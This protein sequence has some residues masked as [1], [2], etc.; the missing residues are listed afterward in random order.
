[1]VV[2]DGIFSVW[3]WVFGPDES[4]YERLLGVLYSQGRPSDIQDVFWQDW[5]RQG[6]DR[7]YEQDPEEVYGEAIPDAVY[8]F[9]NQ[10]APTLC[11]DRFK[12][13]YIKN[14]RTRFSFTKEKVH[15]VFSGTTTAPPGKQVKEVD[16]EI[17]ATL[18]IGTCTIVLKKGGEEYTLP[19]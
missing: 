14:E 12:I 18:D 17:E 3:R 1:M 11:K 19:A 5:K 10:S 4:P 9:A 8:A 2:L 7:L 6:E 16:F 15:L 13:L